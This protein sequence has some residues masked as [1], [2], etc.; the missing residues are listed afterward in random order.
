MMPKRPINIKGLR[1]AGVHP[2]FRVGNVVSISESGINVASQL[3]VAC[4]AQIQH[5]RF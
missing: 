5:R 1:I 3:L 2:L 4:Y